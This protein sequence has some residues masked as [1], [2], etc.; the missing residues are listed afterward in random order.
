MSWW[1][2]R[3]T[4]YKTLI[5]EYGAIAMGTYVAIALLSFGG[6]VIAIRM[7]FAVEGAASGAGTFI[8]AWA[9]I[10]LIQPF[11]IAATLL[12]TPLVARGLRRRRK[13]DIE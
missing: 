7:G 5:A 1:Q 3:R 2:E 11:R 9:G 6:F 8:A 12:L 4:D 13:I 10:K